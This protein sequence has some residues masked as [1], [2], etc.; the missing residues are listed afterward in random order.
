MDKGKLPKNTRD[1]TYIL[2]E[3]V[4]E[5]ANQTGLTKKASRE[6]VDGIISAER[7]EIYIISYTISYN[8]PFSFYHYLS[9]SSCI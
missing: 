3:L 5:V 9:V 1:S 7:F 6:A 4:E 2:A 8:T